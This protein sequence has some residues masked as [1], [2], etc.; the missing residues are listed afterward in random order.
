MGWTG[1]YNSFKDDEEGYIYWHSWTCTPKW[2]KATF[3]VSHILGVYKNGIMKD[4]F[5]YSGLQ[6]EYV[7]LS[8]KWKKEFTDP[9][10]YY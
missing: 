4:Y 7:G 2:T 1:R 5:R 8:L 10:Q 6:T 9:L 3:F